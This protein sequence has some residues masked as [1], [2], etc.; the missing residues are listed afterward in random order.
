MPAALKSLALQNKKITQITLN[1]GCET[2][3]Y[4]ILHIYI[5]DSKSSLIRNKE[6]RLAGFLKNPLDILM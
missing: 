1:I 3:D 6:I 4:I 5:Y 2:N